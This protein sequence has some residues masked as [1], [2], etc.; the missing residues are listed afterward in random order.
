M[1]ALAVHP[2]LTSP[3]L[4]V[5]DVPQD[6]RWSLLVEV[7]KPCGFVRSGGKSVTNGRAKWVVIFADIFHGPFMSF[8]R[9]A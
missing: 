3:K 4:Y 7:L 9:G 8:S 5:A 1:D 6:M 2:L